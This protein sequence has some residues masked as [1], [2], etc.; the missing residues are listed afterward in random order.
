MIEVV[1]RFAYKEPASYRHLIENLEEIAT[2]F[3]DQIRAG[4]ASGAVA[5]AG[6]FGQGLAA[7]GRAAS[8]PIYT[9]AFARAAEL[10]ETLGGIAKPSGAGGGDIGV[11]MFAAAEPARLFAR[12]LTLPLVALAVD[13]DPLGV[14]RRVPGDGPPSRAGLFHA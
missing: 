10:A 3:V 12:A 7:L 8:L 5:A 13:L 9:P 11:A 2:Q 4:D 14:R 6:R 1:Q